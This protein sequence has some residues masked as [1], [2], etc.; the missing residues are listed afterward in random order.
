MTVEEIQDTLGVF[1]EEYND[2]GRVD[3]KGKP[4]TISKF[5]Y[6][7]LARKFTGILDSLA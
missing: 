1:Y 5:S 2:K 7:E 4:E 6:R 3:Y